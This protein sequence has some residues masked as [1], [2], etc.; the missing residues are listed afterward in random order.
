MF[1]TWMV[2]A[3]VGAGLAALGAGLWWALADFLL[4][5]GAPVADWDVASHDDAVNPTTS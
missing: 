1:G 3:V 4:D 5:L 2:V